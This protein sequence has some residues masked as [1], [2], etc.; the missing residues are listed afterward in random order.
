MLKIQFGVIPDWSK[1]LHE[2]YKQIFKGDEI[3]IGI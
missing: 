2:E 3:Y 1:I